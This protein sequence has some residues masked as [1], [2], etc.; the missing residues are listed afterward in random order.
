MDVQRGDTAELGKVGDLVVVGAVVVLTTMR[1]YPIWLSSSILLQG[2][3]EAE[4]GHYGIGHYLVPTV[5]NG[6]G[7]ID[8]G[9]R[10]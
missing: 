7:A 9:L 4:L 8:G 1:N 10:R 6:S 3:Q 5:E 2:R